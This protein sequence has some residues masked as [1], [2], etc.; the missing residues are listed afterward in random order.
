MATCVAF[1]FVAQ[2]LREG[3]IPL[4]QVFRIIRPQTVQVQ[5]NDS[6]FIAADHGGE[7]QWG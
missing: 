5:M 6:K 3:S 4:T 1:S 2:S 7:V